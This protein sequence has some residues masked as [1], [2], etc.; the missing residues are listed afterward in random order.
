MRGEA[1]GHTLQTTAIVHEAYLRLVGGNP[2]NWQD[3]TH[4]FAVVATVM[5]RVLVDYARAQR[6]DKRGG[7][8]LVEAPLAESSAMPP[9]TEDI[10]ALDSA[11]IRLAELDARQCRIV[12]SGTSP[13]SAWTKPPQRWA[14]HPGP[15]SANGSWRERGCFIS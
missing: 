7:K 10:I 12:E 9:D 4:F 5:R 11:L 13:D 3:R 15:S 2:V 8:L 14:S 1:A 6:A